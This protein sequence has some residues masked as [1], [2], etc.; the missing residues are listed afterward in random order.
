MLAAWVNFAILTSGLALPL[1]A[2]APEDSTFSLE[3]QRVVLHATVREGKTRF[4]GTSKKKT[5]RSRKT[6]FVGNFVL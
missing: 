1:F 2:Q 3:V 6:E 4:V 5:S